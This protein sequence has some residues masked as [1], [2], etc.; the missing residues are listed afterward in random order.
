MS[1]GGVSDGGGGDDG[2]T[3]V[4]VVAVGARAL[5][6]AHA[7]KA[8]YRTTRSAVV[9]LRSVPTFGSTPFGYSPI[10]L[11]YVFHSHSDSIFCARRATVRARAYTRGCQW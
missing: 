6:N 9:A 5:R 7:A 4:V 2:V 1:S 8:T 11:L 10:A 3:G